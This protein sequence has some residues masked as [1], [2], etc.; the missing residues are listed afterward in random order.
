M[1]ENRD[2]RFDRRSVENRRSVYDLDYFLNAGVERRTWEE[3][4]SAFERRSG[5]FRVC[6]W[7]SVSGREIGISA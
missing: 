5:W 6:K 3:R 4:R 7:V 1:S 2:Y